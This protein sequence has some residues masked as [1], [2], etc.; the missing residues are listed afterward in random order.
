MSTCQHGSR[1]RPVVPLLILSVL[2]LSLL[3]CGRLQTAT[4]KGEP[5][6]YYKR[7]SEG[8]AFLWL[9]TS[10]IPAFWAAMNRCGPSRLLSMGA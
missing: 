9:E 4:A 3:R 6:K 2:S 10:S 1:K 5:V 8:D 7:V